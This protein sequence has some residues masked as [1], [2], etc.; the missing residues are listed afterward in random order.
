[1]NKITNKW[2]GLLING[3]I[4]VSIGVVFLLFYP[5]L[6]DLVIRIIG[7]L[8]IVAGGYLL[9][10]EFFIKNKS[11]YNYFWLLEAIFN[12]VVG[13]IMILN[14]E[15][16]KR[17]I[18]VFIGAWLV[19][20]SILEIYIALKSSKFLILY[21]G[22]LIGGII[23]LVIG[24]LIIEYTFIENLIGSFI[25]WVVIFIGAILIFYSILLML[26]NKEKHPEEI[27]DNEDYNNEI[28]S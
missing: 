23:T 22:L 8:L 19:L 11:S 16:M 2:L 15:S 3:L 5:D 14:P 10:N 12:V 27:V 25:S 4:S 6:F 9:V 17:M 24:G 28:E 26:K 21:Q 1:M 18:F 7:G 20:V 13:V